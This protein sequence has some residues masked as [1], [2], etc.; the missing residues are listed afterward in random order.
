[1]LN[2]VKAQNPQSW[3]RLVDVWGK[4]VYGWCRKSG[5]EGAE[6]DNIVQDVFIEIHKNID[7]FEHES[8]RS[9]ISA[10]AHNK[11]VDLYRKRQ[12]QL[13]TA[14]GGS[15]ANRRIN[16][17]ASPANDHSS[18]SS[19]QVVDDETYSQIVKRILDDPNNK[20]EIVRHVLGVIRSDFKEQTFRAFCRFKVDGLSAAEVADELGMT[21]AA[22]RRAVFRVRKRLK[23]ELPGM[24]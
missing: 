15:S 13:M 23:D 20:P 14:V 21:D 2:G 6:A 11:M 3:N 8:F 24:I 7:T 18:E 16:A 4:I 10:I 1:M 19:G 5:L 17:V 9:W 22:V 12:K